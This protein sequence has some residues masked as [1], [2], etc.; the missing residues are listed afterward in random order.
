MTDDEA[1]EQLRELLFYVMEDSSEAK[2]YYG[3]PMDDRSEDCA[4][5]RARLLARHYGFDDLVELDKEYAQ[6]IVPAG[7]PFPEE[8][9]KHLPE[10]HRK[11]YTSGQDGIG[12]D[13]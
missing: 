7:N 5:A 8:W 1:R 6:D 11:H 4:Y 13:W 12:D 9:I 3:K 10:S 2:Y